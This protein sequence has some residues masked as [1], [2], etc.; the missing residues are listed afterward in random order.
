MTQEGR[1]WLTVI[2]FGCMVLVGCVGLYTHKE[3]SRNER[4][5]LLIDK[6]ASPIEASCAFRTPSSTIVPRCFVLAYGEST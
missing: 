3:D 2:A 5:Q 6:G 4:I 1:F